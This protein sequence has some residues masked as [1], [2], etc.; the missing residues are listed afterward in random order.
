MAEF[1]PLPGYLAQRYH[2]WKATTHLENRAWYR[3]LA[4]EGARPREMIISCC[5]SRVHASA[6]FG[7]DSDEL[8][9]H[10]NIAALVP[11]YEPDGHQHSTSAAIEYAVTTLRVSHMIV[12]GHSECGG[13]RSCYRMCNGSAPELE[14]NTSFVG[15]WLDI[16]RPAMG[17][18]PQ[19]NDE[20]EACRIM[21]RRAVVVSLRNLLT[22]P[23]VRQAVEEGDLTL[24]GLWTDLG[25]GALEVYD[26][27]QDRFIPI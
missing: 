9:V 27:D 6:M 13:V 21:E 2:G 14:K 7:S 24:H 20:A 23:L 12:L 17:A 5:D 25:E 22:F 15:R 18:L 8:F 3:R 16:L 26:G 10:R 4:E 1:R 19:V 11:H